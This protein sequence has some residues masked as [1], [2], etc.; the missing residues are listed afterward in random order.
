MGS[1]AAADRVAQAARNGMITP[2]NK[3]LRYGLIGAGA[4]V[5][6]IL[7]L[8]FVV[9]MDAYRV[10]L[11]TAATHAT[12]RSLHIEGPLRLMLFPHFGLRAE[13]VTFANIPGGRAAAMA[14]VGDIK[15]AIQFWPLLTGHLE[16]EQIVLDQPDIEL[17]V[18]ARGQSNWTFAKSKTAGTAHGSSVTLPMDTQFSGIKIND[19]RVAYSNAHTGVQRLLDH[20]NANIAIT[21]L[22]QPVSMEGN[23]S[24]AGR[25]ID[26]EGRVVTV[27]ALLSDEPS[28]VDISLTS[29]LMQLS[30]KGN[31]APDGTVDGSA[32]LNT[33][34]L[35]SMAQWLSWK[36]PPGGGLGPLSLEGHFISKGKITTLDP[37]KLSLDGADMRGKL[38]IDAQG[39]PT[40]ISGA[41]WIDHLDLNPYLQTAGHKSSAAPTRK[42]DPGWSKSPINLAWLKVVNADLALDIG[43]LRVR[44]LRLGHTVGHLTLKN[45]ALTAQLASI[46]LYG[47]HG[48]AQLAVD[49]SGAVPRYRNALQFDHIALRSFLNDT[50][51]VDRIEGTGSIA[52]DAASSGVNA[53][54]VMHDLSGKG[55][56]TVSGG[57]IHGVDLG[58]VARTIRTVLGEAATGEVAGTDF[59]SMGASFVINRG[60]LATKDFTLSGPLLQATGAGDI[61]L[62][63]RT[64]DLRVV[65]KASMGGTHASSISIPFRING[66]WD[67]VH[68]APDLTGVV[69]GVLQNLEN[70]RAPFKGLFGGGNKSQDQNPIK[71]KKKNTVDVLKNMFGIH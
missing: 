71:K 61:G 20:V 42:S 46:A 56:V 14:R 17:E 27:K 30:F 34:S 45:E 28:S 18:D 44:N 40:Q 26:F 62:G 37:I 12:G 69:N 55:S 38:S 53:D 63:N 49:A 6:V 31:L 33:S 60:V 2:M 43:P 36:I 19:G 68:Y 21:R 25:R 7:A 57:R 41:L 16:I 11:E 3:G 8:P 59:H 29:D 64:L 48:R 66:S 67:H 10:R 50:M 70:G 32:K 52:L 65:P 54:E 9:P 58:A 51:G 1:E 15:L 24:V 5:A 22:D 39:K 47:G 35:R 13:Q 4:L 23:L